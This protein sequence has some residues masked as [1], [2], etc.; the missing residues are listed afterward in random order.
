MY[1]N[2]ILHQSKVYRRLKAIEQLNKKC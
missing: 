1:S 2:A